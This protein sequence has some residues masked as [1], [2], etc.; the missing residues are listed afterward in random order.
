MSDEQKRAQ[1]VGQ[2]QSQVQS[3]KEKKRQ[4]LEAALAAMT[5]PGEKAPDP[6]EMTREEVQRRA[7][8]QKARI[9]ELLSRGLMNDRLAV[10][11]GDPNRHYVW[12]RER[13]EDVDRY[14]EL[15]YRLEREAGEGEHETPDN[16]RRVGDLVLMSTEMSN[17]EVILQVK[18]EMKEKNLKMGEKEYLEPA[19][20]RGEVPVIAPQQ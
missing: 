14:I 17:R 4:E 15:G 6:G 8:E 20:S 5:S 1:A 18:E 10:P 11:D 16:R 19:K 7:E 9:A 12:V 13:E 3:A 2:P